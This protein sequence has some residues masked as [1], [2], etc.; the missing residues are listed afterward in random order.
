M[1]KLAWDVDQAAAG[2]H[3]AGPF[4]ANPRITTVTT[5]A[6]ASALV[7]SKLHQGASELH[8]A[9]FAIERGK[10]IATVEPL[11]DTLS[12]LSRDARDGV[13]LLERTLRDDLLRQGG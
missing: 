4:Y 12:Q 7:H 1:R 10:V 3:Y 5:H 2:L 13:A 11:F 9:A 8:G 6:G